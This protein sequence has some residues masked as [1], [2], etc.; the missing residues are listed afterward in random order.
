M[1][2]FELTFAQKLKAVDVPAAVKATFVKK[3]P[4]AKGIEWSKESETE[5][6]AEFKNN[7]LE[8][9]ANFDQ[10]GNWVI[11]ESEIKSSDLPS[12]VKATIAKEFAGYKID[13][14]EKA[15]TP[16]EGSFY[17]VGLKKDK[18]V[19]VVQISSDGE[20]LK[21]EEGKEKED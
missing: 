6:E 2:T 1:F 18:S 5:F 21:K 19:L 15:E 17:E 16:N 20:V 10:S 9:A 14:A 3:F 7:G 8:Q 13:E 11:T 4:K 12:P